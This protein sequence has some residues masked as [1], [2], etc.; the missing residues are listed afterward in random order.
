MNIGVKEN[1]IQLLF[2]VSLVALVGIV[3]FFKWPGDVTGATTK[4]P[5][6][7][8][9]N[10]MMFQQDS[11]LCTATYHLPNGLRVVGNGITVDCNNAVIVGDI[12][13]EGRGNVVKDCNLRGDIQ[14]RDKGNQLVNVVV[15]S[16][17]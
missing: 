17:S 16:L 5:C 8:P 9:T 15:S 13:F 4:D 3:S 2:I 12:I 11:E 6:V 14:D 7:V 10:G 1:T